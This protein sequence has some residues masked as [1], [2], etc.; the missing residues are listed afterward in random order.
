MKILVID[1]HEVVLRGTLH[2]LYK[3]YPKA[4]FISAKTASE[5]AEKVSLYHPDLVLMDLSL[6]V[7]LGD[8]ATLE[9]GIQLLKSFLEQYPQLNITVQSSFVKALVRVKSQID[10][11]Q[12]GF[13]IV[14]KSLST[15][16]MLDRVDLALRGASH[17]KDLGQKIIELKPEWLKLLSLAFDEGLQDEEIA[18]RMNVA[19]RTV[20]HY[21]TKIQDVLEVYP[22]AGE[23]KRIKTEI[24]AREKC[25]I[26]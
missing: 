2:L 6:P 14:D 22:E 7:K 5:A 24:R 26:D 23:N 18:K 9:T 11:H 4:E 15:Q 16:D 19:L 13:T 12:G 8:A 3:K 25:L 1:D 21:W 17:T 10:N 20:R